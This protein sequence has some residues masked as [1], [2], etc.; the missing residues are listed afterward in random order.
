MLASRLA[1]LGMV[2]LTGLPILSLLE[3]VGGVDPGVV[4]AGFAATAVSMLSLGSLGLVNSIRAE[5]PRGAMLRTY[6]VALGYLAASGAS[7]IL[8]VP[9]LGLAAFPSTATW[10]SP[11]TLE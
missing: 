3:F 6:L 7:L 10:A 2:L 11:V 5:K 9:S 4:W 8:V 1:N